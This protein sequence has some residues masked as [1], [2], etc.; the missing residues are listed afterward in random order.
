V[1]ADLSNNVQPIIPEIGFAPNEANLLYTKRGEL[2]D[3]V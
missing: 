1:G 2:P 3:E